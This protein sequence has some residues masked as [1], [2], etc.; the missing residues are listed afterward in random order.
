VPDED[1]DGARHRRNHVAEDLLEHG[2]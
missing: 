2:G 1:G